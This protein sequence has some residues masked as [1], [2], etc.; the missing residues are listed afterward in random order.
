MDTSV[1]IAIDQGESRATQWVEIL[2]DA[3]AEG[4]LRVCDV[5]AA[6]F[7]AVVMDRAAFDA[8]LADLGIEIAP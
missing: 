5:V 6:E 4:A 1:L 7:F 2:A 8:I 3:R